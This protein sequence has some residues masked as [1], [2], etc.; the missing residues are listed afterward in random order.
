MGVAPF[1]IKKI[2][3]YIKPFPKKDKVQ[4]KRAKKEQEP[5]KKIGQHNAIGVF[6]KKVS[7]MIFVTFWVVRQGTIFFQI[8]PCKQE[9]ILDSHRDNL[10]Y[11]FRAL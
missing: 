10:F 8:K 9:S 7:E 6:T 1:F 5:S 4:E 2:F 11:L 3:K